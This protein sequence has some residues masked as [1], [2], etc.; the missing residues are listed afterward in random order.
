MS[1]RMARL[2]IYPR[3]TVQN[4]WYLLQ[5]QPSPNLHDIQ[6]GSI[7][8]LQRQSNF[9]L[10]NQQFCFVNLVLEAQDNNIGNST[11]RILCLTQDK[12]QMPNRDKIEHTL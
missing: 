7:Q 9:I 6:Y 12:F 11:S 4:L 10:S 1:R 3:F 2:Y 8:S 5:R